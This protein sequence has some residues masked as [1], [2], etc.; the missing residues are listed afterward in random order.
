NWQSVT[1][2]SNGFRISPATSFGYESVSDI[3]AYP[4]VVAIAASSSWITVASSR[5]QSGSAFRAV[6]ESDVAAQAMGVNVNAIKR[7]AFTSSAAYAGIAGGM[8]TT[9][10]SFIHPES[11]GFQTTISISTMVVVGGIGSVRGAFS[12]A[13]MVG[14]VDTL[15]RA[16][17]PALSRAASPP[18]A[19]N[20]AG[21]AIASMSIYI[22]M[23]SV[24]ASSASGSSRVRNVHRGASWSS[25]EM[26]SFFVPAVMSSSDHREFSGVSGAKSS[27]VI[28][29][30]T[31]SVMAGTPSTIDLCYRW[32]NRHAG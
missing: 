2:G 13:S 26:S 27:V 7:T 5:S 25:G 20:A 10:A 16:S 11:S 4:F 8:Y 23:A 15:G 19:A 32:M 31:A 9:F 18:A 29:S 3:K 12:A 24:S 22:V 1:N 28:S 14:S 17:S 30:G 6:R 21:P